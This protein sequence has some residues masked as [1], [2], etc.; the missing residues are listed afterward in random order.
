M[1]KK[2]LIFLILSLFCS[3]FITIVIL[4]KINSPAM[5]GFLMKK[6]VGNV[7]NKVGGIN[8]KSYEKLTAPAVTRIFNSAI[9]V[10]AEGLHKSIFFYKDKKLLINT[11]TDNIFID[12]LEFFYNLE[13]ARAKNQRK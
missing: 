3:A 11:N 8:K 9:T 7:T 5:L 12:D 10:N 2:R 1:S 4:G 6:P 13:M